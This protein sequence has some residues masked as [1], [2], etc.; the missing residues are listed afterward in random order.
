MYLLMTNQHCDVIIVRECEQ[1]N[2]AAKGY[3]VCVK[4]SYAECLSAKNEG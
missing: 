4:G 1:I 3:H 2:Y